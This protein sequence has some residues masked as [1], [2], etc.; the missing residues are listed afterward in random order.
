[1]RNDEKRRAMTSKA[2]SLGRQWCR[3]RDN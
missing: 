3:S 2:R 1:M